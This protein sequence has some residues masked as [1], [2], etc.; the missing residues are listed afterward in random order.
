MM[1]HCFG[2]AQPLVSVVPRSAA[3][4]IDEVQSY[5]FPIRIRQRLA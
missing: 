2:P 3:D 1:L 4:E 5:Q